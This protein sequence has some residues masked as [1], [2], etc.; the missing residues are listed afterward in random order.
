MGQVMEYE[1]KDVMHKGFSF[2]GFIT[3]IFC[4]CMILGLC[5][6]LQMTC[7]AIF[8]IPTDS[9]QPTLKPGD[10]ILVNKWIMG[11]RIFDIVGVATRVWKSVS[12]Q[13]GEVRWNRIMKKIE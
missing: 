7:A 10:N 1:N 8:R 6:V 4:I 2:D 9:M 13:D 3:S 5:L 11:A 12:L